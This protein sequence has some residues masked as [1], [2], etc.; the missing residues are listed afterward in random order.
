MRK[1]VPGVLPNSSQA[2]DF[3]P[4]FVSRTDI[5]P[6]LDRW[7]CYEYMVKANTP[8]QRDG[9]IAFWFDGVLAADFQNLR[10]RDIDSLKI[11]RFGLSFHVGSNANGETKK[12]YDNVVAAT[13]YIGPVVSP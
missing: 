2:F 5:I 6:D 13:S 10:L 3:G 9:R 12:W 8:G 11:D 7:Y 4:D 1:I